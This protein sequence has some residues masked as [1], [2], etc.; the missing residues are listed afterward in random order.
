MGLFNLIEPIDALEDVLKRERSAIM[1][2]DFDQLERLIPEKER[3]MPNLDKDPEALEKLQ[4]LRDY[5]ARN[6]ELLSSMQSGITAAQERI[7]AMRAPKPALE[8]YDDTGR[9][10]VISK[11]ETTQERR[12]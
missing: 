6:G 7:Q 4:G 3:L 9:K 1:A 11:V 2:G 10:T 8:T 12:A 5:S